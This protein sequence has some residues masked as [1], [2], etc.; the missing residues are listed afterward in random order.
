MCCSVCKIVACAYWTCLWNAGR[1]ASTLTFW[2]K[3]CLGAFTATSY[4]VLVY[5]SKYETL[6]P[7]VPRQFNRTAWFLSH[8]QSSPSVPI[9]NRS[10]S[11][12]HSHVLNC[13]AD[14][15][16]MIE[17]ESEMA[18]SVVIV[19]KASRFRKNCCWLCCVCR[20][21]KWQMRQRCKTSHFT[22]HTQKQAEKLSYQ[23]RNIWSIPSC[24]VSSIKVHS[25]NSIL[26]YILIAFYHVAILNSVRRFVIRSDC[27]IVVDSF[28]LHRKQR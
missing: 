25:C 15:L 17:K 27:C 20:G 23:S 14:S 9:T 18:H 2:V 21:V 13:T 1:S 10:L 6:C 16:D 28:T 5:G 3:H 11:K 7:S 4:V 12:I 22:K 19:K 26:F 8:D 24:V